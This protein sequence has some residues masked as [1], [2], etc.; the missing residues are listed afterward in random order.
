M[1]RTKGKAKGT[2]KETT[3]KEK[4]VDEAI[5]VNTKEMPEPGTQFNSAIVTQYAGEPTSDMHIMAPER[6]KRRF[7]AA[8]AAQYGS[9][10]NSDILIILMEQFTLGYE[11]K[12]KAG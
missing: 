7:N 3:K 8:V 12:Q 10:H 1:A 4:S 6:L 2:K 5:K 9:R 11:K